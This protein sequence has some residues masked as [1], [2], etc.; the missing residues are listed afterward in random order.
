MPLW[1]IIILPANF[2]IDSIVFIAALT[3]LK[4]PEKKANYKKCILRI[5]G[6]GFLADVIGAGFLFVLLLFDYLG[7]DIAYNPLSS[8]TAFVATSAGVILAG[9]CIYFFNYKKVLP[10]LEIADHK[11][12]KLAIVLAVVT[13]PYTM[14]LPTEFFSR[15]WEKAHPSPS[16][17]WTLGRG[18]CFI[19]GQV[20]SQ[21]QKVPSEQKRMVLFVSSEPMGL[22][23][24]RAE[25][26]G[27][28]FCVRRC[29]S[30]R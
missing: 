22:E 13:A 27:G 14:Y 28:H 16:N 25:V 3:F 30:I 15:T 11:R 19:V 23:P 12:K 18:V 6:Y 1:W 9:I 5:W 8:P 2:I 7:S 29:A 17:R 20:I 24:E 26:S 4:I 10:L 21:K